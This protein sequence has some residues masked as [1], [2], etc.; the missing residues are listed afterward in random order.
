LQRLERDL[1]RDERVMLDDVK[2]ALDEE[3]DLVQAVELVRRLMF[4]EKLRREID[5]ALAQ[6]EN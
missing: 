2:D 4:M 1:A 6:L 5:D 3:G